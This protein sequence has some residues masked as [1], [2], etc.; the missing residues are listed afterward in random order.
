MTSAYSA[1][2]RYYDVLT[3]NVNYKERA[4]Y[5]HRLI[6]KYA[7]QGGNLLLDLACGTGSL[8]EAFACLGYDVIGVDASPEMLN[9]AMEKK[10]QSGLPIQ[11]L[12]QD[13]RRLDL[14]GTVDCTVCALDSL[15][16]L[17]SFSDVK[18][19][20]SRVSLFAQPGGLFLFDVNTPYKHQQ[21]L[22][23][24]TFVY[25]TEHVYCVWQNTPQAKL[26]V[27]ITLD[28]FEEENGVWLR[29]SEQFTERA[30]PPELLRQ[31]L[32]EAGLLV[33]AEYA[34]DTLAL[35]E[36]DTER[37]VFVAQKPI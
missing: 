13:M 18:Q 33:L 22:G 24:H 17:P 11:Y 20:F 4:A 19:V 29:S 31:A 34:A 2:A 12:C 16:H 14:F 36:E 25:E 35:P 1:F 21:V 6:S 37:I 3:Q 28:F 15:N 10:M 9:Q 8:S 23:E 30:Y 5:F 32:T 27:E 26:E 7:P